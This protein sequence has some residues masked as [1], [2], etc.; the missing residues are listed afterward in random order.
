MLTSKQP[1]ASFQ[2]A[3][4]VKAGAPA[5]AKGAITRVAPRLPMN[6]SAMATIGPAENGVVRPAA[7]ALTDGT[8]AAATVPLSKPMSPSAAHTGIGAGAG[9]ATPL[10]GRKRHSSE[11]ED[12][13]QR[14]VPRFKVAEGGVGGRAAN[15]ETGS[16]GSRGVGSEM[17]VAGGRSSQSAAEEVG[18]AHA[19]R[20]HS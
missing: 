4:P 14:A 20:R 19:D 16:T 3:N 2:L 6:R 11:H 7:A 10:R 13:E 17:G 8:E 5:P 9:A 15:A 18:A 12:A 1:A